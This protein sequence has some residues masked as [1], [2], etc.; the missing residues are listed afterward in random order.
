MVSHAIKQVGV[1]LVPPVRIPGDSFNAPPVPKD[2]RAPLIKI[3]ILYH[4]VTAVSTIDQRGYV[5]MEPMLDDYRDFSYNRSADW[6]PL[7][8]P[9]LK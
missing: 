9:D 6:K 1:L 7:P 8:T 4:N 5:P 2:G 3:P